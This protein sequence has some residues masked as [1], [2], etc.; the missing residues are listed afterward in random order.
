MAETS[1]RERVEH[2]F[3]LYEKLTADLVT[4]AVAPVKKERRRKV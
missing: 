2:L 1:D 3:T 4:K